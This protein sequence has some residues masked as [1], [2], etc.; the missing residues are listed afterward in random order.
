MPAFTSSAPAVVI[1]A[2]PYGLSVAAHLRGRGIAVRTFG[3]V[4]AGWHTHMPAGMFLKSTPSASSLSAPGTGSTLADFCVLSGAKRLAEDDVVPIGLFVRYGQ[5]FAERCVPDVE[6]IRVRR[7]EQ[8]GQ[9][10]LV[11]L[12]SG[13]QISAPAVVIT[14]GTTGYAHVPG[15]LVPIAPAGPAPDGAVSHTWQHASLSGFTGR[16]VAVIGAGQSALESAALLHEAGANVQLVARREVKWGDAPATPSG[17]SRFMPPLHS[18]LGPTWK[19]IP[20][21][22]AAGAFRHLP[23]ATR[24]ALVKQVL[25]PFGAWWLRDRVVGQFP[26]HAGQQLIQSRYV[27]DNVVLTLADPAGQQADLKVDHVLAATGYRVDLAGLDFMDGATLRRVRCVAG[28]P[29][30]SG[31]FESSVPGV[32]FAGLASAATFGPLMRFVCGSGF[33]ARRISDAVAERIRAVSRA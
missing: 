8:H 11:T 2:G 28:S 33:A 13:E 26:V 5:W 18:P 14:T 24:L 22:S 27:G 1:G 16:E 21:S 19:L 9:H 4:M 20:F 25:G 7:L 17:L 23:D 10:C 15:A 6:N 32:Y 30:L 3:D 31:S 12:E 29:R